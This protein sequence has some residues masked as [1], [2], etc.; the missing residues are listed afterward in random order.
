MALSPS[1]QFAEEC[2]AIVNDAQVQ[3]RVQPSWIK[4]ISLKE[5]PDR[6]LYCVETA[7][8]RTIYV[9]VKYLPPPRGIVGPRPFEVHVLDPA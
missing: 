8:G 1:A 6:R 9:E 3:E 4:T 5:D 2:Q 7:D